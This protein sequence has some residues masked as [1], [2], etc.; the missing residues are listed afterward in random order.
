MRSATSVIDT[1]ILPAKA[2]QELNDFY[3]F[4]VSKYVKRLVSPD[5]PASSA[6]GTAGALAASPL[7]GIWKDRNLTD[8]SAFARSLREQAQNRTLS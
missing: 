6:A 4:L 1:S 3:S 2:R 8:S 7:V 5:V